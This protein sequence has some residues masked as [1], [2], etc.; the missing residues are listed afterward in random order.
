MMR[1]IMASRQV[2]GWLGLLAAVAVA[3]CTASSTSGPAAPGH[4]RSASP[5][6][7]AAS[8]V[9]ARPVTSSTYAVTISIPVGWQPTPNY[10]GQFAY[11]GTS[12]WVE[13]DATADPFG[14]HP[15]CTDETLNVLHPYGLH[16]LIIYRSI[17][18]RPGCL[19]FPSSGAH[20]L[21]R[22]AGGPAFQDSA[23]LVE[24]WRPGATGGGCISPTGR[25]CLWSVLV[26]YADPAHLMAIVDSVQLHH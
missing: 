10:T 13:L 24:Y 2:L 8:A 1:T 21:A 16:P 23:A 3:G 9:P 15:R 18:G 12:G 4:G 25:P 6:A 20:A 7:T 5:A 22:R 19:I 11:D 17:D 26:I 14:L